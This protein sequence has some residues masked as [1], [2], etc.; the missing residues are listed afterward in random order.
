MDLPI[1][2][3]PGQK[4]VVASSRTKRVVLIACAL[5]AAHFY[6]SQDLHRDVV[7]PAGQ[8]WRH[9]LDER[10]GQVAIGVDEPSGLDVHQ[11]FYDAEK[12]GNCGEVNGRDAGTTSSGVRVFV[13][14]PG[15]REYAAR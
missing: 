12:G 2:Q 4:A 8:A 1:S 6:V 5:L 9:A 14:D 7:G 3:G 11:L 13:C 10:L 15:I